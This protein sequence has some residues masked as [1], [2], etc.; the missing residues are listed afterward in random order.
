MGQHIQNIDEYGQVLS[1]TALR[2]GDGLQICKDYHHYDLEEGEMHVISSGLISTQ[3]AIYAAVRVG[4]DSTIHAEISVNAS[5]DVEIYF[6]ESPT[7]ATSGTENTPINLNRTVVDG[8]LGATF[9][10]TSTL[11]GT[12]TTTLFKKYVPAAGKFGGGTSGVSVGGE[13]ILGGGA[14]NGTAAGLYVLQVVPLAAGTF[15]IAM[16]YH[17]E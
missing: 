11:T 6:F 13:W 8:S 10:V 3:G 5:A 2:D 17:V 14:G 1:G 9:Y 12:G 7:L 16:Q 15:N 4:T